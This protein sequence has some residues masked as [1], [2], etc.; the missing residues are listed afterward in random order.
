MVWDAG[1]FMKIAIGLFFLACGVGMTYALVRLAAVLQEV[2][3]MLHDVNGE[4]VPILTRLQTTVDEVNS[5]LGKIDEITGSVVSLT[6]TIGH[7]TSA[8]QNAIGSP[9]KKVAGFSAGVG[10]ALSTFLSGRRKEGP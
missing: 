7:T 10:E 6:D 9:V 5:E 3:G 4:F 1:A 8:I 2:T